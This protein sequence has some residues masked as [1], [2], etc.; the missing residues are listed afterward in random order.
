[1][2]K[3][4]GKKN[5]ISLKIDLEKAFDHLEWSFIRETLIR[6][7]FPLDLIDLIVVSIL[8]NGGKLSAFNPSRGIYQGD[9]LS[10]YIFILC[11]EYLRLLIH[12]KTIDRTWKPIEASRYGPTFSHLFFRDGLILFDQATLETA[13]LLRM[14]YHPSILFLARKHHIEDKDSVCSPFDILETKKFDKYLGFPL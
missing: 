6:F 10:P 3:M 13:M 11:L 5:T 12:E 2:E 9:P 4:N 8:F 7:N 1:M 14:C